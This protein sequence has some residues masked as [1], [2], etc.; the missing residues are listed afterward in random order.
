MTGE[1]HLAIVD[2]PTASSGRAANCG[3]GSFKVKAGEVSLDFDKTNWILYDFD[4][5]N[6]DAAAAA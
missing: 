2:L 3:Q 6:R 5:N 1:D 4:W